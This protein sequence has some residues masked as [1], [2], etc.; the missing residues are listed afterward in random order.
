[1]TVEQVGKTAMLQED[2]VRCVWFEKVGSRQVAQNKTFA[3]IVLE[4]VEEPRTVY[5][6]GVV[7]A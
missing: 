5:S 4:K 6:V 1:M 3:P 2:A 7:R